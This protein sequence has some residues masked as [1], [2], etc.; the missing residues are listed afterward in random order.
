MVCELAHPARTRGS[1]PQTRDTPARI[2]PRIATYG[3][4]HSRRGGGTKRSA[5]RFD[6]MEPICCNRVLRALSSGALNLV[7]DAS[8][9]IDLDVET[10]LAREG[11]TT[12]WVYFPENAVI[13]TLSTYEDGSIIEM[14]NI[15]RESCTGINLMLGNPT[16]F[17]TDVVQVGG[18]AFR[19]SA[20]RFLNLQSSLPEFERVLFAAIQS[21]FYQVMVSGA[22]NGVHDTRQRL[23]RWLLTMDDRIDRDVMQLTHGFLAEFLAVRRATVTEIAAQLQ[24]D[25]IIEYARGK[26]RITDRPALEAVSCEC[27]SRV[28]TAVDTMLPDLSEVD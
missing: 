9:R 24:R 28:C 3:G 23:A 15:G 1:P 7:L 20:E 26:I 10:V 5:R 2:A 12:Y 21:V 8:E 17:N 4:R 6:D 11:E 16:Q 14:A 27:Y 19:M 25:G 18:S 22:C 13:S